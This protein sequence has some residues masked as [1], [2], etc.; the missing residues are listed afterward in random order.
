M[1]PRGNRA[2]SLDQVDRDLKI[3]ARRATSF[4]VLMKA[5]QPAA[6]N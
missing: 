2:C 1:L 6:N 4:I 5:D 3:A